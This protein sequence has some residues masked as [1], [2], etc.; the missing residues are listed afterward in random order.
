M[1]HQWNMLVEINAYTLNVTCKMLKNNSQFFQYKMLLDL[2]NVWHHWIQFLFRHVSWR[3]D[4]SR[5][6]WRLSQ[7][8][9]KRGVTNITVSCRCKKCLRHICKMLIHVTFECIININKSTLEHCISS[10]RSYHTINSDSCEIRQSKELITMMFEVSTLRK[11]II[12]QLI[13]KCAHPH[14]LKT[15]L[16]INKAFEIINDQ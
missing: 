8:S 11:N 10:S 4:G 14:A 6:I 5:R 2:R 16:N 12:T 7:H 1:I 13:T 9:V 15:I 3:M